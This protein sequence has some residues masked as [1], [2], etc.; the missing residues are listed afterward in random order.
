MKRLFNRAL[1][2]RASLLAMLLASGSLLSPT[3]SLAQPSAGKPALMLANVYHPGVVLA[4]YW[5]S[6]KYDYPLI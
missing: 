6:E 4:D 5:V 1:V 3:P 2:L